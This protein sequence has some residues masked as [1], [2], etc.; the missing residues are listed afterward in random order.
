MP[1]AR[2]SLEQLRS[3]WR[4]CTQCSLGIQRESNQGS[5]IFGQG[6][7]GGVMF[8]G[9]GPGVD[10]EES[11]VPFAGEPGQLLR[12]IIKTL[13]V[14]DHYIT[15]LVTCRS[16]EPVT[17]E[18]GQLRLRRQ[19]NGV[20]VPMYK[21]VPPLPTQWKACMA[22]L[23]EEIYL[24]D[25]IVIV[26]LGGTA[27]E[28]LTGGHVTIT[29]D[30]GQ[31]VTIEVPGAGSIA[32]LTETRHTWYRKIHGE[33]VAPVE[34]ST[35]KYLLIPTLH[36]AFVLRKKADEGHDSLFRRLVRDVRKAVKLYE[37]YMYEVHQKKPSGASD[38]SYEDVSNEYSKEENHDQN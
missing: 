27:A 35:V 33:W 19:R 28:A 18:Q 23:H 1:D 7:R 22:R 14:Q 8:I 20:S 11:G 26:S 25:P 3:E 37:F 5:F 13:G 34:Q 21:D 29:R 6:A 17:D 16:C 10:E 12:S 38:I 30:H 31:E 15:N 24:V 9:D 36:P 4:S 2:K 32:Q